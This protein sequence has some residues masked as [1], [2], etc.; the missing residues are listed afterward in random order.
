MT[1]AAR[2]AT[3]DLG[4]A[5]RS[6][7]SLVRRATIT[8]RSGEPRCWCCCRRRPALVP[9]PAAAVERLYSNAAFPSLQ[10]GLTWLSNLVPFALFDVLLLVAVAWVA[11]RDCA[12]PDG[13]A[14]SRLDAAAMRVAGTRRTVVTAAAVSRR[15]SSTWGLNYRRVRSREAAVRSAR[16]SADAAVALARRTVERVNALYDAA[17]REGWPPPATLDRGAGRRVRARAAAICGVHARCGRRGPSGR[18]STGISRA[19]VS[20]A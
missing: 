11:G 13:R 15:S 9:L 1:G 7:P 8:C 3:A 10:R 19:P 2:H 18:S 6:L 16:V 12:R 5:G 14:R 20:P 4:S 17:H